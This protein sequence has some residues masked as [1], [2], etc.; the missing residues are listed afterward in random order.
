MGTAAD[1][2]IR[3]RRLGS[4]A[5]ALA[6][7]ALL[8]VHASAPASASAVSHAAAAASHAA[9]GCSAANVSSA[10]NTTEWR[11]VPIY[12]AIVGL[13]KCGTTYLRNL[14]AVHPQLACPSMALGE[15]P[16]CREETAGAPM[17][18]ASPPPAFVRRMCATVRVSEPRGPGRARPRRV[19]I[20]EPS[21]LFGPRLPASLAQI[22]DIRAVACI[23]EPIAWLVSARNHVLRES[24]GNPLALGPAWRTLSGCPANHTPAM[25]PSLADLALGCQWHWVQRKKYA[26]LPRQLSGLAAGGQVIV[27]SL[28][29]NEHNQVGTWLRLTRWLGVKSVRSLAEQPD[30]IG[31]AKVLTRGPWYQTWCADVS[32]AVRAAVHG[33]FERSYGA[34]LG[35]VRERLPHSLLSPSQRL[36]TARVLA[37]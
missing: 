12:I 16:R 6:S 20:S 35:F 15:R 31:K 26:Q 27:V 30:P 22:P 19:V 18:R 13:P 5:S 36:G 24:D 23:R 29:A 34:L 25:P 7:I 33:H 4:T 10:T 14:L 2:R 1:T 37:C 3:A 28:E 9:A 21:L 11:D 8:V 32:P 17:W